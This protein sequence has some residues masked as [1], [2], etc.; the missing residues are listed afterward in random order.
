METT[1]VNDLHIKSL[2]P[3]KHEE[4]RYTSMLPDNHCFNLLLGLFKP[5]GG[6]GSKFFGLIADGLDNYE[7]CFR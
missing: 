3:L 4:R 7:A 1:V 6:L 5:G 2:W